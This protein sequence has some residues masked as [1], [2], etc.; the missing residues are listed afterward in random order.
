MVIFFDN[1]SLVHHVFIPQRQMGN[2]IFYF[3]ILKCLEVGVHWN[4]LRNR[5]L[6][7]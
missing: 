5:T 1:Q 4:G 6:V 2:Q 3:N 7:C